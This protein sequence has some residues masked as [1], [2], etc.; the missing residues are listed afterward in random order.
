M[1]ELHWI[2]KGGTNAQTVYGT[3]WDINREEGKLKFAKCIKSIFAFV[4]LNLL[5]ATGVKEQ[6]CNSI[7]HYCFCRPS[8]I[9]NDYFCEL[10]H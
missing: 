3:E 8:R 7:T 1:N 10:F 4:R 9:H 5:K 2:E 6:A